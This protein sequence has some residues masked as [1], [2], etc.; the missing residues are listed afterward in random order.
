MPLLQIHHLPNNATW[1]LWEISEETEELWLLLKPIQE[2]LRW[3]QSIS[4]PQKQSESLAARLAV[5]GILESW[6][7]PYTYLSKDDCKKPVLFDSSFQVSISHTQKYAVALLHKANLVGIDIEQIRDKLKRI[8]HKFLSSDELIF[9]QDDLAKMTILWAGKEALYKYY[10][11]KQLVF[12]QDM[13]AE[14]FEVQNEGTFKAYLFP[15]TAKMQVFEMCY[16][17]IEDYF[18]VWVL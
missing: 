9:T 15:Q 13:I 10:G 2:D 18:V 7:E 5:R 4:H 1:A 14:N 3:I 12:H 16:K 17:R 11:K 8:A 6:Q